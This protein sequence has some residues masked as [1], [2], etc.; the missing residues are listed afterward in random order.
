MIDRWQKRAGCWTS[1]DSP[2]FV[3]GPQSR[4]YSETRRPGSSVLKG[5]KKNCVRMLRD[6]PPE[7][8]RP[9]GAAYP[10]HALRRDAYLPGCGDQACQVSEVWQGEAREVSLAFGQPFLY[11]TLC[12]FRGKTVPEDDHSGRRQRS[13]AGLAYGQGAGEA[14]HDRAAPTH[15]DPRTQGNRH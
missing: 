6:G 15:G 13:E 9:Q 14:I 7:F 4:G 2:G 12:F 8:L 1:T 5:A 3:P 11:K 10:G